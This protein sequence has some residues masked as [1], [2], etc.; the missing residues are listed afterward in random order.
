MTHHYTTTPRRARRVPGFTLIELLVVISIISLLIGI[1]LPALGAARASAR[2]MACLSN[3]RQTGL[4]FSIYA[5]DHNDLFPSRSDLWYR[6]NVLGQYIQ[7]GDTTT[8]G[9]IGGST[10]ACPSDEDG[11][12]SYSMNI[13]AT[14]GDAGAFINSAFGEQFNAAVINASQMII[15][16]ESWSYFQSDG[17]YFAYAFLAERGFTPY[18]N[19]VDR[20]VRGSSQF[21]KVYDPLRESQLDFSRHRSTGEPHEA[22]GSV[23]IVFVDGHAASHTDEQMVDRAAEKSTY[24]LL[25]SPKDRDV[26]SN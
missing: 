13:Y 20:P 11:A 24:A 7:G 16:S 14:S 5:T 22:R 25:W 18:Q 2:T 26:E 10:Y 6:A 21:G 9:N 19:F 8:P 15:M 17:Q 3:L 4:A 12:R 23:N 1:L